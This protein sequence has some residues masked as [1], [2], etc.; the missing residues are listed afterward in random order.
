MEAVN[1]A[2]R[3]SSSDSTGFIVDLTQPEVIFLKNHPDGL[4]YQANDSSIYASWQFS[5]IESKIA[6]YQ[7]RILEVITLN[8]VPVWPIGEAYIQ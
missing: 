1:G 3:T 7:M 5:D 8:K 4:L 2:T 6:R